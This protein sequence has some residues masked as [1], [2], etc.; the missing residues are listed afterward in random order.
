MTVDKIMQKP[1]MVTDHHSILQSMSTL[2][3]KKIS[4]LIV[5]ESESSF[6]IVTAKDIGLFLLNDESEKSFD[7]IS[8]LEITKPLV[9]IEK[10]ASVQNCAQIMLDN[11]I[12]SLGIKSH[13]ELIGIV[14]KTDLVNHYGQNCLGSHKV[15]DFM[16]GSYV[17]MNSDEN[18][19][20]IISTMLEKKISRIFL[21]KNDGEI[22]GILTFR[23][24]FPL[25]IKK[26]HLNTLKY[27]DYPETSIFHMGE[28]FGFTTF[29]KDIMNKKV[30]SVDQF[31][32][33]TYACT[34]LIENHIGGV[35]VKFKNT[36]IGI[37][38]KTDVIK[39]LA[40]FPE[41]SS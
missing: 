39:A 17:S 1:I 36:S 8:I 38:S 14:T 31:D 9:T 10:H 18:L 25:A 16:Q 32:D 21:T 13:G 6:G 28:G 2:L 35:G 12:G 15:N 5:K 4:R 3:E 7:Y 40:E 29:A 11:G 24:L 20:S 23:D 19:H 22:E 41:K 37:L 30:V 34:K 27:N 26:G 33:L